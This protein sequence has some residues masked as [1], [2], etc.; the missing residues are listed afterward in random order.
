MKFHFF[1][2]ILSPLKIGTHEIVTLTYDMSHTFSTH[3]SHI[4]NS[5]TYPKSHIFFASQKRDKCDMSHTVPTHNSH[6]SSSH[7][8]PNSHIFFLPQKFDNYELGQ[9]SSTR[10]DPFRTNFFNLNFIDK[11]DHTRVCAHTNKPG[12]LLY[13]CG[14]NLITTEEDEIVFYYR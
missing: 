7:T 1:N 11:S 13:R 3:N 14:S 9:Y 10:S 2:H 4:P 5:N 6:T 8:Y 12:N